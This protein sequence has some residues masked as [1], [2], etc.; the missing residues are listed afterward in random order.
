[1]SFKTVL[2][3]VDSSKPCRS[4]LQLAAAIV[5]GQAGRLVG[6]YSSGRDLREDFA[7][8]EDSPWLADAHRAEALFHEVSKA[9]GV[10]AEWVRPRRSDEN[11]IVVNGRYADLVVV[12]EPN[13]DDGY[14]HVPAAHPERVVLSVG[15]PVLLV[16][17]IGAAED[18]GKRILI[19]WDAS[20]P[21]VRALHDAMPLLLRAE[22]VT[23]LSVNPPKL[24]G[25]YGNIGER[26]RDSLRQHGIEARAERTFADGG[27]GIADVLLDWATD[28]GDDLL[29]MGVHP[30]RRF[31]E[32][33]IDGPARKIIEQM[34][35]PV[36]MSN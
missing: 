9:A 27:L 19:A 20:T 16:P 7:D 31:G 1:M 3:H 34:T 17:Y 2:V 18:A 32:R 11:E 33:V 24:E 30:G 26:M 6:V 8:D 23:L 22:R 29:V 4:R 35:L 10:A 13:P 21:A 25:P 5:R 14:T 15:R 28:N 36:L 12:G